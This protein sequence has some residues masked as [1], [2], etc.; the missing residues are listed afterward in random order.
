MCPPGLPMRLGHRR[1]LPGLVTDPGKR[2]VG[3]FTGQL[4]WA[5]LVGT[6]SAAITRRSDCFVPV[7]APSVA[8]GNTPPD[9]PPPTN[10]M[11]VRRGRGGGDREETRG[12]R[13]SKSGETGIKE[14]REEEMEKIKSVGIRREEQTWGR[15]EKIRKSEKGMIDDGIAA[16]L[17]TIDTRQV[18]V[19]NAHQ[20]NDSRGNA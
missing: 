11:E 10:G 18:A 8:G 12:R 3:R 2:E 4:R 9:L 15:K 7:P 6:Q 5:P 1:R 13:N 19:R 20:P 14:S 17:S 16:G